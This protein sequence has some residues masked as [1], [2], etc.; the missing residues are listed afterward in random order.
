MRKHEAIARAFGAASERATWIDDQ[1][2]FELD[3]S[4][5]AL[6][7]DFAAE[8]LPR[9]AE[10]IY[11]YA[12]RGN[13]PAEALY[14]VQC[15]LLNLKDPKRFPDLAPEDQLPWVIFEAVVLRLLPFIDEEAKPDVPGGYIEETEARGFGRTVEKEHGAFER[16]EWAKP[17]A[18][19]KATRGKIIDKTEDYERRKD[20]K[21]R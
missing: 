8:N 12:R 3:A 4:W 9:M 19:A 20:K 10:Q 15:T 21:R 14:N 17:K 5:I 13:Y 18:A 2:K 1:V 11:D 6:G 7:T 16:E